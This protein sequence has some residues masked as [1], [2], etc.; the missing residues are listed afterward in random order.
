VIDL[1]YLVGRYG[2]IAVDF[3]S[4]R[5][6]SYGFKKPYGWEEIPYFKSE[7]MTQLTMRVIRMMVKY[8]IQSCK[9]RYIARYHLLLQ[10][11][12]SGLWKHNLSATLLSVK[13]LISLCYDSLR[14]PIY[15]NRPSATSLHVTK[16]LN[17]CE[18][19]TSYSLAQWLNF[20]ILCLQYAVFNLYFINVFQM[21]AL[22]LLR[23]TY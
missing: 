21:T 4:N 8:Y 5:V 1:T 3:Q 16:C 13:L 7:W 11:I 12:A 10:S 9:L 20:H 2:D 18:L 17:V 6:S 22:G 23:H 14:S 19:W 15:V